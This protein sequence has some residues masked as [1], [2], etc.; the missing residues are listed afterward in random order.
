MTF[1]AIVHSPGFRNLKQDGIIERGGRKKDGGEV[2]VRIM[3]EDGMI[4]DGSGGKAYNG[5]ILIENDRIA[6]IR[7][8]QGMPADQNEA[9]KNTIDTYNEWNPD[10]VMDAGKKA[11]TPG[12]IDSH[13][14]CD[15]A[16]V[17][18]PDFGNLELAQG[19]TAVLGGNCGMSPFPYTKDTGRQ[20]L[21]FMEPCLGKAPEWMKFSGFPEYMKALEDANPVLHVGQMIGT[22]A[23]KIA[24]KGFE[25]T[26]FTPSEMDRA[27]GYLR[28][29]LEAGAFGVSAGIMYV[30]ECYSTTE[31]FAELVREAAKMGRILTCH[32]RGEGNSLV[33]S[34]EEVLKIGRDAE[35]PVNI[36]HFKA[37]G[38]KNWHKTIYQAMDK[39]EKARAAGQDVTVDFYPYTGGSTTLMT[40]LPPGIQ[41]PDLQDTLRMLDTPGGA[42][43][44]KREIYREHKGWDNMVLDIGWDRIRI[45]SANREEDKPYVGKSI[46]EAAHE[47]GYGDP[48]DFM[49]RLLVKEQ[50][51]VGIL[52][53][54]MDQR[55]VNAIAQL[56]YSMII[57]D[58]LYGNV[59][60]P[61]PRLYGS[62]PRVIHELVRNRRVLRL[63]TAIHKM[64]QMTAQRFHIA[65]RGTLSV[66][67]YADINIF[68]SQR[69][70]D[71]A[72]YENPKRPASGLDMAFLDGRL[73][74]NEGRQIGACHTGAMRYGDAGF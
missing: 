51:R 37:V 28:E 47:Q 14:H 48:A 38:L 23:V 56:P 29:A 10:W 46:Q 4:Y 12:F 42:G 43:R 31:E 15:I 11:V 61:H 3:I 71:R 5:D 49:C 65:G 18:D 25:K 54:S 60:S 27:K 13:R 35:I 45:S 7:V 39:I 58:S 64:T 2:P 50:G 55:D 72:T 59:D 20:M 26:P 40:L 70:K 34:V 19:I 24:A 57:S 21:D 53:M 69:L 41:E 73:V 67:N 22:G 66:G 17:S 33:S 6:A 44:L 52:L 68:D 36:S 9:H 1:S 16:A 8:R 32:I 62:F 30:P 74:W 63:E